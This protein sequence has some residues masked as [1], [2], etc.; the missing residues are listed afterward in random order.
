[1]YV[2]DSRVI[3]KRGLI[4]WRDLILINDCVGSKGMLASDLFLC[5]P[6]NYENTPFWFSRWAGNQSLS[7]A[8]P[9]LYAKDTRLF[10]SVADSSLWEIDYWRWDSASR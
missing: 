7:E 6:N 2:N 4:W 8:Y 10:K 5:R 9:E 1:M 3:S